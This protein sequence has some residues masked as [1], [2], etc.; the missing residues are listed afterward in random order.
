M[1]N[2]KLGENIIN[3][4]CRVTKTCVYRRVE[5]NTEPATSSEDVK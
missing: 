5:D 2:V 1:N 4:N 3:H